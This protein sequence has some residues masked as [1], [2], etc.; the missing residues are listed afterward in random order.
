MPEKKF[1]S[2]TAFLFKKNPTVR[3]GWGCVLLRSNEEAHNERAC[4]EYASNDRCN[5]KAGNKESIICSA[6]ETEQYGRNEQANCSRGSQ[7]ATRR[8]WFFSERLRWPRSEFIIIG[9]FLTW[10]GVVKEREVWTSCQKTGTAFLI[11]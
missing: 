9:H 1:F 8:G 2:G 6:G 10:D 3:A 11:P 7:L 4:S 5:Q